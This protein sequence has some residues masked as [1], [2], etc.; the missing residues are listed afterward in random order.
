MRIKLCERDKHQ[1]YKVHVETDIDI[2][3]PPTVIR[4]NGGKVYK[5]LSYNYGAG[6]LKQHIYILTDVYELTAAF[7]PY[8][9]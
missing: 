9:T 1:G 5:Y 7:E 3:I 8:A 2:S 6:R 4:L